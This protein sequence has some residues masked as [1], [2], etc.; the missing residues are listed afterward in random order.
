MLIE[1]PRFI[2]DQLVNYIMTLR[3]DGISHAT[4][5]YLVIPIFTFYTRNNGLNL[6][7]KNVFD[8]CGEN[9]RVRRNRDKAYTVEQIQQALTNADPR[10]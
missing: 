6:N 3:E 2:E 4:I 1:D 8:Y 10:K 7:K 5:K 9:I